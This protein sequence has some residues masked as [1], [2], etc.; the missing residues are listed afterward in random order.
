MGISKN[1]KNKQKILHIAMILIK[2]MGIANNNTMIK[3]QEIKKKEKIKTK[4]QN[5]KEKL[6][7]IVNHIMIVDRKNKMIKHLMT[8]VKTMNVNSVKKTILMQLWIK[9]AD[10]ITRKKIE[11]MHLICVNVKKM[12]MTNLKK[13]VK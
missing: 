6:M 8:N 1:S 4:T 9:C 2:N 5:A 12:I 7:L 13:N 10:H 11:E 3:K